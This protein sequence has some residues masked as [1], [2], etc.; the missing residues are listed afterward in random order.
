MRAHSPLSMRSTAS[1]SNSL[2]PIAKAEERARN[3]G[4]SVVAWDREENEPGLLVGA[5]IWISL[6]RQSRASWKMQPLGACSD[7]C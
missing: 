2:P 5:P 1:L 4:G 6:G 7:A 3:L